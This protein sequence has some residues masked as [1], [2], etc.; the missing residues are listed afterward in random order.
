[1]SN[2]VQHHRATYNTDNADPVI[3]VTAP[4]AQ[5]HYLSIES[6]ESSGVLPIKVTHHKGGERKTLSTSF[7]LSDDAKQLV[8]WDVP[9]DDFSIDDSALGASKTYTLNYTAT[10]SG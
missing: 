1:M 9:I 5:H 10:S 8:E 7:D 6:A 3:S 4:N 2:V